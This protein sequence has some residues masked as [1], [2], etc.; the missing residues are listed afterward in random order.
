MLSVAI[1]MRHRLL[2]YFNNLRL[3]RV[4]GVLLRDNNV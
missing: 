2:F 1:E 4:R 3:F